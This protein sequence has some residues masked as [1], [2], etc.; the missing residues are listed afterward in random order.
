[1]LKFPSAKEVER[2][3]GG[4]ANMVEFVIQGEN[5]LVNKSLREVFKEYGNLVLV[6]M[7]RRGEQIFIPKGDFVVR[8]GDCLHI[9]GAD[10][11]I[12]KFTKSLKIFKPRAKTAFI[13]GGGMI[14]RYLAE[15]LI[16]DGVNV[17]IIEMDS[18]RA[19][20]L[21]E[22]LPKAT[23]IL[24]DG[25]DQEILNEESFKNCDACISLTGK[26]EQNIII[27]LYAQQKKLGKVITKIDSP[28]VLSM[29]N[30]LG[31]D[32]VVS[33]R[34]V[35]ANSIVRFVR[36]NQAEVSGGSAI[37]KLYK[38]HD[39]VEA[40]EFTVGESFSALGVPIKEMAIKDDVLI[41]GIVRGEKFILPGGDSKIL[42]GDKVIIV[43]A[44]EQITAL[45]QILK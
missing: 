32:T 21:A 16:S 22:A 45:E 26:D 17:K 1:M 30:M 8:A 13:I 35:I 14:A 37:N 2:F 20:E 39:E 41:G 24:G 34:T 31:L 5:P 10:S 6:A 7:V 36:A 3:A 19:G 29:V 4:R 33:P 23:V 43:T 11:D 28:S 9:I 18:Q 40:L 25:K 38:F 42:A 12:A 44:V 27:S 15:A